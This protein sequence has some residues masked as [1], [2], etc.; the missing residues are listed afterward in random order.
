MKKM[1]VFDY[2]VSRE[3]AAIVLLP[4][5]WEATTSYGKGTAVGPE[6]ILQAS[7]QQDLFDLY[8]KDAYKKGFFW[9]DIPAQ[10][11][12]KSHET[13]KIAL[14]TLYKDAEDP[15]IQEKIRKVNSMCEE[16]NQWTYEN[17]KKI[18]QEGKICGVVGGDHSVPYGAIQAYSEKYKGDFGILHFDAHADLR[19]AYQGFTY[20]HASIFYNVTKQ[21]L[22][23]KLVQVGIRDF[24]QEEYEY[25]ENSDGRIKTFFDAELK[26]EM[27]EGKTW[28][29][30]AKEIIEELPKNVYVSV[31][32]DGLEPTLGPNTGTPVVGGLDFAQFKYLLKVL[33]ESG[34]KIIGFDLNEVSAGADYDLANEWDGNVGMRVLFQLC[35]Y[36]VI[37]QD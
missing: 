5:P 31:D 15:K 18:L 12:E 26:N 3:N 33:H 22:A 32:I 21:K 29:Q 6:L 27:F 11:L 8:F 17:A 37:S 30:L 4:V 13:T 16:M 10:I 19:E 23:K 35:G 28:G 7:A 24:C 25:I 20:S 1:N 14:S 36:T 34:R 9:Q 2:D